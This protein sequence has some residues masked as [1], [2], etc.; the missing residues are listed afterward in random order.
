MKIFPENED[1]EVSGDEGLDTSETSYTFCRNPKNPQETPRI[2]AESRESPWSWL[3]R[4]LKN[5]QES[6][7]ILRYP[8]ESQGIPRNPL[9][10]RIL[11]NYSQIFL[12]TSYKILWSVEPP[13]TPFFRKE[14]E[15][16]QRNNGVGWLYM[17]R[18]LVHVICASWRNHNQWSVRLNLSHAAPIVMFG[19]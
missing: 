1:E 2:L 4:I 7:K 10:L 12:E 6:S 3:R 11:R 5:P 17:K 8:H 9:I 16:A 14:N 13:G 15:S 18:D 19:Q